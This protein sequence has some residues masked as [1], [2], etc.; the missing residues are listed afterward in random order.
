MSALHRLLLLTI[1]SLFMTSCVPPG[2]A[3]EYT[4]PKSSAGQY[5]ATRCK[6]ALRSC[7]QICGLRDS[8][9]ADELKENATQAYNAYVA[10]CKANKWRI[11]K[12]FNDFYRNATCQHSCNCIPAYNTC[13]QACGGTVS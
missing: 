4:P 5:C 6:I 8:T 3:H 13:Y 12:S 9:C 10:R 11:R 7:M 1:F 2:G